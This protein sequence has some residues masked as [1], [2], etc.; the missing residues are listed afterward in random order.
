[1]WESISRIL[2]EYRRAKTSGLGKDEEGAEHIIMQFRNSQDLNGRSDI[3][4]MNGQKKRFPKKFIDLV[5][6][7]YNGL[8]PQDKVRFQRTIG[9]NP[10]APEKALRMMAKRNPR[11]MGAKDKKAGKG[12]HASPRSW[13]ST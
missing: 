13:G 8:K 5:L 6:T 9:K 11:M 1:M 4:F 7:V 10:A 2:N 12:Y 3:K